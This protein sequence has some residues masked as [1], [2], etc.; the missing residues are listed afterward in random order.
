M[1]K[2]RIGALV[3]I[4]CLI[5]F[6]VVWGLL[7]KPE[8]NYTVAFDSNG[9]TTINGQNI[10]DGDTATEP[11]DPTREGYIFDGWYIDGADE[12]YDFNEEVTGNITL[13][14]KWTEATTE[15][16][17][18]T[19]TCREGYKLVN[20]NSKNCTCE[21][22]ADDSDTTKTKTIKVT[23]VT[24]SQTSLTLYTGGTAKVK[25][26]V[27]PNNATNKKVTWKSSNENV[28]KV[29]N[30]EITAIGEGSAKITATAGGKSATLTVTVVSNETTNT[31]TILQDAKDSITAKTITTG[32][33]DIN[34]TYAGCTITNTA[35]NVSNNANQTVVSGGVVTKLYRPVSNGSISSTY[36]I[37]CEN[38]SD[39]KTVSHTIAASTYTYTSEKN[40][41]TYIL[42]VNGATNYT[43]NSAF[44]YNANWGGVQIGASVHTV[45]A[46][47]NM[48]LDSDATTIYQVKSAE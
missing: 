18:C 8:N 25:A 44:K 28:V 2:T 24:L 13:K 34:Y 1:K 5:V 26:T 17:A 47:Y 7:R 9:G 31:N 6:L 32:N 38:E 11:K 46:N 29:V 22:I 10:K 4:A 16:K 3:I 21:K 41:G 33:T 39:T 43:L 12:K 37:V 40:V 30:G 27:K 19:L 20:E 45:G 35:N 42:K 48:V 14:A 23:S 36:N 15:I